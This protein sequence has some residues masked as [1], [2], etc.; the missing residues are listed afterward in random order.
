MTTIVEGTWEEIAERAPE[1]EGRRVRLLVFDPSIS[2]STGSI[3]DPE[4]KRRAEAFLEWADSHP[5]NRAPLSDF[6]I[7]RESMYRDD[8]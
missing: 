2:V 6:A 7:S 5:P 8:A 4:A 1:F 3:S